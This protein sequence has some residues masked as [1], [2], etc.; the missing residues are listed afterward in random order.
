[1]S[2][3]FL[4]ILMRKKMKSLRDKVK[5]LDHRCQRKFQCKEAIACQKIEKVID[6][7]TLLLLDTR[8]EVY[9]RLELCL[10]NG[11]YVKPSGFEVCPC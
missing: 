2:N 10:S 9:L 5:L 8:K 3:I 6:L 4:L 7:S 11:K 1:M